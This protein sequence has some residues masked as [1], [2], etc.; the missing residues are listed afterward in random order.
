MGLKRTIYV[1]FLL[2]PSFIN[3]YF[4]RKRYMQDQDVSRYYD[5]MRSHAKKMVDRFIKLGPAF[6]KLGQLLSV[7]ADVLPQPYM[8]EFYR[9][10]D[11]V[12]QSP[13]DLIEKELNEEYGDY[14]KV[15]DSFEQK[16]VNAASLGE[17]HEAVY[18]GKPVVVK[19]L[20][21]NVKK[22]ID[23]DVKTIKELLP[24]ASLIF[25][26]VFRDTLETVVDQFYETVQ[27][28][29]D[30]KKEAE[31]MKLL[32]KYLEN[33]DYVIVP[34]VIEEV[35]TKRVL[36]M[37]RLNGIKIT[38][39][40]ELDKAGFNRKSLAYKISRVYLG[41]VLKMEIFH[42]D[43]HPGNISVS[44]DGKIIIY[45]YGMVGSMSRD[46]RDK[47]IW[48]Y[49]SLAEKNPSEIREALVEIGALDPFA[50]SYVIEK[51]IEMA[52]KEMEGFEVSEAD[53]RMLMYIANRVIYRFPF[54]LPKDLVL[55]LRMGLLLD[56]VCRTLDP[57]FNFLRILPNLMRE[58][59]LIREY[60]IFRVKRLYQRI[61]KAIDIS[62]RLPSLM[63]ERYQLEISRER[64][65]GNKRSIAAG[66]VLGVIVA[67]VIFFL[68]HL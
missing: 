58:E 38:D 23:E 54:R 67:A 19:I 34:E 49:M 6:I 50:N 1:F 52:L 37:E 42:A 28:E 36:V 8:D 11:Q 20:R 14:R 44:K 3:F 64:E 15:F 33:Y 40:S 29:M 46:L 41:M 45:D 12:P 68:F 51:G 18:K 60:Y 53:V 61:S 55:Y 57:D 66:F 21:P 26:R 62:L 17:V 10:Q 47:M 59:G 27:D 63:Q 30:Y 9:L 35:S 5:K 25:G 48:L 24:F 43:P 13:F 65:S 22:I 16:A 2:L 32:K 31:N 4:D 39:V 56:S 7:R